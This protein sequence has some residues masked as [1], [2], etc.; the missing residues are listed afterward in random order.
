MKILK[1]IINRE[2]KVFDVR[3]EIVTARDE[4]REEFYGMLKEY[5]LKILKM[6]HLDEVEPCSYEIPILKKEIEALFDRIDN[7]HGEMRNK[8]KELELKFER[9]KEK[10]I[11]IKK[12]G[13]DVSV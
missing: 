4:M 6:E 12:F 1:D 5:R 11:L 7:L 13:I 8:Y 2:K 3:E 9:A 10:A